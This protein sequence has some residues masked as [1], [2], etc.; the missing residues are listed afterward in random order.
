MDVSNICWSAIY[1]E[2]EPDRA[3]EVFLKK[4]KPVIDKHAPVR[5]LTVRTQRAPWVDKEL[6]NHVSEG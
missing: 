2:K 5:K 6:K 1:D 4:F 3:I